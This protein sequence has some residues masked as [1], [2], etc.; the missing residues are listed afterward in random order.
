MAG[1]SVRSFFRNVKN[2]LIV[3]LLVF[4]IYL[5]IRDR[6]FSYLIGSFV[7]AVFA[8]YTELIIL[9]IRGKKLI[10]SSSSVITGLIIG[11]VFSST[12][13]WQLAITSFSSIILKYMIKFKSKHIFNP[14]GLGLFISILIFG[15]V[16]EW[17]GTSF[18][19]ILIP[20]GIYFA[21]KVRRLEVLAGYSFLSLL[22]F[23]SFNL[24][25]DIPFLNL[26]GYFSY[27]YIFVMLIEPKT[28]PSNFYGKIIFG[29]GTAIIIFVMSNIG[30]R[31]DNELLGLLVMNFSVPMLNKLK[32]LTMEVK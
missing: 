17:K 7:A 30:I 10:V 3:F 4:A 25:K 2:Q 13:L 23:G 6:D 9:F 15:N 31:Y 11:I 19:Y 18:W 28:S 8:T 12:M 27:F 26:F 20:F 32:P 16:L 14:A 29:S 5:S 22:L 21:Y 1:I 24:V